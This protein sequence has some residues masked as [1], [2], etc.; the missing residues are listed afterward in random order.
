M[1][2]GAIAT[3]D[4]PAAVATPAA[5][6]TAGFL[7]TPATPA[8]T[9]APA[10]TTPSP[11]I[12]SGAVGEDG[13]FKEGWTS[14]I[15]E[16]HPA[17]ANQMMRYK[18]EAD[19]FTGL[20]NLV[21]TVG[22]KAAGVSYPKAGATPEEIA[23]FR[24][25]AGVPGRAE[26]YVLKPE[27]LPDGVAWDDATGKQFAEIM[28][29]NHIP[30]AAA[31]ALVEAHLQSVASQG[32]TEAQAR[33]VKLGDLVQKSTAEFQREWGTAY[34]D[35]FNAN[36]DFVT[37]R[38]SA[39]DLADPAL[40][41]ALSHPAMVRIIDEARRASRE[42]PL[43][44]VNSSAAVGSMSP[45]QQANEIIKANPQWRKDPAL[46]ARVNDLYGQHAQSE[47]RQASR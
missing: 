7:A 38:L 42:A 37:A 11:F 1:S 14:A 26:E 18:S 3:S 2:E 29:A 27:K 46:A 12:F 6:P 43:P 5:A 4:A 19:A 45:R 28:H 35:R 15:A 24:T 21:K 16:K 47:K 13:N 23:A 9:P 39:E 32:V 25:D 40:K 30:A 17:L 33:E 44:G 8:A 41:V 31:K 22:K 36:S 34:Q 20:E 10:A